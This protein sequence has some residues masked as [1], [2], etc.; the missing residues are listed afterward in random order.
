M[1]ELEVIIQPYAYRS[2]NKPPAWAFFHHLRLLLGW[3]EGLWETLG[4]SMNRVH[5]AFVVFEPS[6]EISPFQLNGFIDRVE[7][8]H[9]DKPRTPFCVHVL[10]QGEIA[11]SRLHSNDVD[12]TDADPAT[13]PLHGPDAHHVL[14]GEARF[15]VAHGLKDDHIT[16]TIERHYRVL[17]PGWTP[18]LSFDRY[19]LLHH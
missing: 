15:R 13:H 9:L 14:A 4:D 16:L 7:A 8:Y 1:A 12:R 5:A 18:V 11:C 10:R 3:G 17:N 6:S 19:G 2:A